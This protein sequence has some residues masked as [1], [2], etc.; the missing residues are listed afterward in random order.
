[1]LK[2]KFK[3]LPLAKI[4]LAFCALIV[5]AYSFRLSYKRFENYEFGKFDLGNMS[6]IIWNTSRGD[7]MMVTDQFGSNI[8]RLGMS[9]ADYIL[10]LFAPIY[11]FFDH[12]MLLVFVQNIFL[13]S[14]VIPIYLL[15]KKFTKSEF[16][17]LISGVIYLLY[18]AI[19]YLLVWSQYHGVTHIAPLMLWSFW[20]LERTSYQLV[21]KKNKLIF[22]G[23]FILMLI[24]KE[25]VGAI[26][27]MAGLAVLVKNKKLGLQMF[28]SGFIYTLFCFLFLIP[29]YQDHRTESVTDFLTLVGNSEQINLEDQSVDRENFFLNRYK[30]LGDSYSN[31]I[32]NILANPLLLTEKAMEEDKIENLNYLYKPFG[33]LIIFVPVWLISMPDFAIALLADVKGFLSIENQRV[34]LIVMA[35]FVS[36]LLVLKLIHNTKFNKYY[37]AYVYSVVCLILTFVTSIESANPLFISGESF[38]KNKIIKKV[39]SQENFDED[40][41]NIGDIRKGNLPVNGKLCRDFMVSVVDKYNPKYYSGPNPMGAHT[42]NRHMNAMF[43][44]GIDKSDLFISDIYDLKTYQSMDGLDPF[45]SNVRAVNKVFATGEYKYLYS[46]ENMVAFVKKSF[47]G[48]D[49]NVVVSI[50]HP[51]PIYEEP[52]TLELKNEEKVS[53]RMNQNSLKD[54]LQIEY[55]VARQSDISTGTAGYWHLEGEGVSLKF[56]DFN[57]M[58]L[59]NWKEVVET[60]EQWFGYDFEFLQDILPAGDYKLF[61]GFGNSTRSSEVYLSNIKL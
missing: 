4:V 5:F 18:P 24:G 6:Q 58:H 13:V 54:N 42:A 20:Y 44:A 16:I 26:L 57:F 36:Y 50:D 7:F 43:P 19:G 11:W 27:G 3:N 37:L 17:A 38:V 1:M 52:Y 28:I 29:L 45:E 25:Q 9:H 21:T 49:K 22:W 10:A 53:I 12:P 59:V 34:V 51:R 46:C 55:F 30:Y 8:N 23:L 48:E 56:L 40:E 33:Y 41:L 14:A 15:A 2:N 32:K 31:I 39:Y 47:I 61:Y 35:L 60:D